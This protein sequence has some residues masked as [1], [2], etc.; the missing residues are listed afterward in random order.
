MFAKVD[1]ELKEIPKKAVWKNIL[2]E[3]SQWAYPSEQSFKEQLRKVKNNY[4]FYKK[5]ASDLKK[6]IDKSHSKEIIL[7]TMAKSILET[8]QNFHSEEQKEEILVL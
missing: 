6:E 7:S 2:V 5:Q 4:S 3:G 8:S 1:Y